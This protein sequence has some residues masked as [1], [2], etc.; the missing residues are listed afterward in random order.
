MSGL[1]H[2]FLYQPLVNG[3]I[4]LYRVFG[5]LGLAVVTLTLIIR[6][7]LVP[8]T[9]SSLKAAKK[10]RELAPEIEKL[11]KKYGKDRQK[12]AQ[13]QM[14]LYRQHGANPAAGC[15]P[16][17]VQ[18]IVLIALYRA[19]GQVLQV[20][21]DVIAKLNQVLYPSLQLPL[22]T[23]INTRFFYLNLSHPDVFR[24]PGLNFSLPGLFLILAALVQFLSSKMMAPAVAA[25]QK[26]AAKTPEKTDDMATS[27]QS[28]MLYMFPLMTILIGYSFPSGL[29][30]Y[31][32]IFSLFTAV[33]Q[34]LV[35][36]WGGLTP[37]V[38][39]IGIKN[40]PK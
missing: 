29:V 26:K 21:G 34:Y 28:Q 5:N 12:F 11:K 18:L 20:D 38:A 8:L 16:Q 30:L 37:W 31:W 27:M 1:W 9:L 36:G 22:E 7:L 32:F 33:Q 40:E 23:V 3:L 39:K 17:I 2:T 4:F 25:S 13:A 6:G 35:G 19:F 10:M 15:L 14:E 24:L